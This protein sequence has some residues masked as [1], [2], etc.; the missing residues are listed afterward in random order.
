[1]GSAEP[2]T[3]TIA[4]AAVLWLLRGLLWLTTAEDE[5]GLGACVLKSMGAE[6]V[7]QPVSKGMN[8]K[9]YTV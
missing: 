5:S 2:S 9:G 8:F 7:I 6:V 3:K 1:M 4:D